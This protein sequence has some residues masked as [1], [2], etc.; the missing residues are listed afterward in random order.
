MDLDVLVD[1]APEATRLAWTTAS[2]LWPVLM[3]EC[4]SV[5]RVMDDS[6]YAERRRLGGKP[7]IGRTDDGVPQWFEAKMRLL[8]PLVNEDYESLVL[9]RLCAEEVSSSDVRKRPLTVGEIV[10]NWTPELCELLLAR[11]GLEQSEAAR[12]CATTREEWLAD[13]SDDGPRAV[14]YKAA[15]ALTRNALD[16][17]TEGDG[18]QPIVYILTARQVPHAQALLRWQGIELADER[19]IGG[20]SPEGKLEALVS[21]RQRHPSGTLRFVDDDPDTLRRV[22]GA[23]SPSRDELT[24]DPTLIRGICA[25][26]DLYLRYL[27]CTWYH[28]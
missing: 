22:A 13:D 4:A 14:P 17:G 21:L 11:Y 23:H 15:M 10:T 18:S 27:Q 25:R 1:A 9:A 28:S 5:E 6:A 2:R 7:L 16:G 8:F 3:E 12:H 26:Y 24:R 20:L 19:V